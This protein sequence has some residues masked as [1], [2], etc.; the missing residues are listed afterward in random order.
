[1]EGVQNVNSAGKTHRIDGAKGI[2]ATIG[3]YFKDARAGETFQG[4][5]V[6][7]FAAAL[8]DVEGLSRMDV[9][10]LRHPH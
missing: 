8:S 7:M 9:N 5:C 4:L 10:S 2:A 6:A 3:Y 1:L